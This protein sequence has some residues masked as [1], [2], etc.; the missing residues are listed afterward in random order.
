MA[1]YTPLAEAID[2]TRDFLSKLYAKEIR[3]DDG[4]FPLYMRAAGMELLLQQ[5]CDDILN[6]QLICDETQKE[7]LLAQLDVVYDD[8]TKSIRHTTRARERARSVT[9]ARRAQIRSQK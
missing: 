6:R 5:A 2:N 9:S 8:L 4:G 3:H 1:R 7:E